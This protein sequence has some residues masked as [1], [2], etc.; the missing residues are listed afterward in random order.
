MLALLAM[1]EKAYADK[2]TLVVSSKVFTESYV[3]GEIIAQT[4]EEAGEA[5]V[6]RELG[7]GETAFVFEALKRGDVHLYA[8]YTGTI[9]ETM[10]NNPGIPQTQRHRGRNQKVEL[11]YDQPSRI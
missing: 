5:N 7:M 10:L 4:I 8:E 1:T 6:K 2:P 11:G 9:S 3:L